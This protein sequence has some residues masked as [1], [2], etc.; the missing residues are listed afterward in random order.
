[1][2]LAFRYNCFFTLGTTVSTHGLSYARALQQITVGIYLSE[3]CLIGLFAISS[4]Q[5][6][7]TLG[8]LV[9]MVIF[10][11]AT[12]LWHLQMRKALR[13]LTVSLPSTLMA[14]EYPNLHGDAEKGHLNGKDATGPPD[15]YQV[16]SAQHEGAPAAS[17]SLVGRI[18]TFF[19]PT[20]YDSAATLSK[21]ILSPHLAAPVRPY[22]E[23]ERAEA[24]LHPALSMRRQVVWVPRD[25][26]GLSRQEVHASRETIGH[27]AFAMTDDA[28]WFD[29]KGKIQWD[30]RDVTKTPVWVDEPKY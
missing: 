26:Y 2:Y 13:K 21:H 11:V 25:Q 4:G 20:K 12:I 1:M 5:S 17:R 22:T 16:L 3:L 18:K 6:K 28:A 24:Y 27:D 7:F 9:I 15:N 23:R 29:D 8:P 14:G 30:Q 10:L 19:M